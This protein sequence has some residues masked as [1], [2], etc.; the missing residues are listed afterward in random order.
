MRGHNQQRP[1]ASDRLLG[2]IPTNP[3]HVKALR[4][5]LS[6]RGSGMFVTSLYAGA[7]FGGYLLGWIVGHGGWQLA[8]EIQMSLFCFLGAIL[9]LALRPSEMSL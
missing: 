2:F 9:A 6:S 3:I 8:G 1:A 4:R 7:A 5:S